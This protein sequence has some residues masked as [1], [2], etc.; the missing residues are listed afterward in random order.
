MNYHDNPD[1]AYLSAT[2]MYFSSGEK[3]KLIIA[4]T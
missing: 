4:S 3:L 1:C 2:A